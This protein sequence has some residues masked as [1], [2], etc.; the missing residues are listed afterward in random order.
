MINVGQARNAHSRFLH[1]VVTAIDAEAEQAGVFGRLHVRAHAGFKHRTGQTA[2]ATTHTVRKGRGSWTVALQNRAKHAAALDLGARPHVIAARRA[3]FLVFWWPKLRRL[4]A[5][6]KVNHPGN[7][8]YRFL[9]RATHAAFRVFAK[10]A[11][12][13]LE[14]I[15]SQF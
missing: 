5:L 15:A 8:P 4:M 2:A 9:Y 13:A 6:R 11:T 1:K 3:P 7:R 10:G 12:S 14:R